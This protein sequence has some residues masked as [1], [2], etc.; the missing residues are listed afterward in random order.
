MTYR[1]VIYQVNVVCVIIFSFTLP[2]F[3]SLN[4][5]YMFP[6]VMSVRRRIETY[7]K[8][9][10]GHYGGLVKNVTAFRADT[11]LS[12]HTVFVCYKL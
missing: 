12:P 8:S 9:L 1:D 4:T 3:K 5:K 6:S 10:R 11:S 7:F 2:L